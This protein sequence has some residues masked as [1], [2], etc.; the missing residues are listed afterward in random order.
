MIALDPSKRISVRDAL[1]HQYFADLQQED[2]AKYQMS[3]I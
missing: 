2:I 3:I 1:Q